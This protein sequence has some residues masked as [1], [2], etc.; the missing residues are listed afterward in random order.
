M[1]TNLYISIYL[2]IYKSRRGVNT[3]APERYRFQPQ[4]KSLSLAQPPSTG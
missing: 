4:P 1:Y 3:F 2:H